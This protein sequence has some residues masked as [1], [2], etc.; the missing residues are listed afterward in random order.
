MIEVV[1]AVIVKNGKLLAFKRGKA[2]FDY[3][4]FKYEFPG[5]KV[6]NGED[7]KLALKR[8]LQEEL[9]LESQIGDLI[10]IVE[11]KYPDFTIK[12]HCFLVNILNYDCTLNAHSE[13][14]IV[15]LVESEKLDWIEADRPVLEILKDHYKDVFYS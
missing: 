2:K 3:V 4:S 10:T 8:E 5:G 6:E 13:Y 1:A 9:N 12:M 15:S 14:A 11:H 7:F